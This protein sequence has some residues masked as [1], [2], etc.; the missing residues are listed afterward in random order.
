MASPTGENVTKAEQLLDMAQ[1]AGF[2]N[3]TASERKLLE[4]VPS[5]ADVLCG[6]TDDKIG[7]ENHPSKGHKW[8]ESRQIRA[9]L[10]R[11]LCVDEAATKLIDPK[12]IQIYGAKVIKMLD[13]SSIS[14][15]FELCIVK[16]RILETMWLS[17][18]NIN[19]LYL[20]GTWT[21]PIHAGGLT[22]RSD[23]F[24]TDGF[25]AAG[26]DRQNGAGADDGILLVPGLFDFDGVSLAG[27]TIGGDLGCVGATF[28]PG[29][30]KGG[31]RTVGTLNAPGAR[32]SRIF[33]WTKISDGSTTKD[34]VVMLNLDG[35]SAG[36]V[37]D[38]ENSWPAERDLSLDGFTYDRFVRA[39]PQKARSRLEWLHRQDSSQGLATQPYEQL[40]NVL[41]KSGDERGA[42]QVRIA[43]END[44]LP[45]LSWIGYLWRQVLR[46]TVAYGYEPWRALYWALGLVVFGY[47]SF[48]L[49]YRAGVIAPTDKDA[50]QDFQ[51]NH[52][53]SYQT[54]LPGYQPFNAFTYS[55]DTFLPIINLGLKD[56]W[57]PNPKLT[58]RPTEGTWL[59]DLVGAHSPPVASWRFFNSGR[60][61]RA[62]LWIHIL[63]G[64][65]L[66]TLFV[67]GFTGIIRR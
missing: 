11:W 7:S 62:Y 2:D 8:H 53:Q 66:I 4:A 20:N 43:M 35:A 21:G 46:G 44:L 9:G 39:A 60:A 63:F 61:L 10:I 16:S 6:P 32:I 42:R 27:A 25:C 54:R 12:G 36:A 17:N 49:G 37:L 56:N 64:W 18:A 5:G 52:P 19:S 65:G 34:P 31:T 38:D 23:I 33:F 59:G 15:P 47:L 67:A 50:F 26:H 24:L 41:E 51:P 14:I 45:S 28:T 29:T 48:A 30:L 57:M 3:L 58:P 40:A 55:L 22:T 13:L 1:R